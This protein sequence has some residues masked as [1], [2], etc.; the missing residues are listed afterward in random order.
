MVAKV[1]ILSEHSE[2]LALYSLILEHAGYDCVTVT[3]DQDALLYLQTSNIDVLFIIGPRSLSFNGWE[4]YAYLK[5]D[6]DLGNIPVII[7]T[8]LPPYK[9]L[10]N[11]TDYGD[12]L[13]VMPLSTMDLIEKVKE[14]SN[15]KISSRRV[16]ND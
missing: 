16:V 14:F 8:P 3:T 9:S 12:A 6:P 15:I 11:P 5:S 7:Y 13:F 4:F 10:P 2:I 1:L